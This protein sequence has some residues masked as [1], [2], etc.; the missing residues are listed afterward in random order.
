[1]EMRILIAKKWGCGAALAAAVVIGF[2]PHVAMAAGMVPETSVV[3]INEADGEGTINVRN[4]DDQAALLYVNIENI[5]EDKEPLVIVASPVSRVEGK[6]TQLVRFIFQAKE[7]VTTQRLKR[8]TF[9]GIPQ[10]NATDGHARV[11]FTV[12]QNLPLLINPKGLPKHQAPWTLLH[13][14]ISDGKLI[15]KNNSPYV[16]RLAEA[17]TTLPNEQ[18]MRLPRAYILPGDEITLEEKVVDENL[19]G[20]R[21][22]PA[23]VYGYRVENYDAPLAR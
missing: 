22:Y 23:T 10:K 8:V 14:E 17:V 4:T 19:N 13:W 15:V 20:V 18:S 7:P 16:V 3:I 6:Q 2:F 12:S 11:A 9:E 5:P 21:I 1:M